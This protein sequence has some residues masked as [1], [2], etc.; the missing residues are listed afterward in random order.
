MYVINDCKTVWNNCLRFIRETIGEQTYKTWFE[1][2]VPVKLQ[3]EVLTIQVPNHFFYEWLEEHYVNVLRK[4]IDIEL[5]PQGRLEYSIIMEKGN[6]KYKPFTINVPT[7]GQA[8]NGKGQQVA[9]NTNDSRNLDYFGTPLNGKYVF[10]TFIEGDCNRL[11]RSA[12]YAVANK[13]GIT[14]FNPLMIFGGTG[15]G[16]THLVQ[17]IGNEVVKAKP[18]KFVHYVTSEKFSNQYIESIKSHTFQ[19][20]YNFYQSVDVLII[21]DVQF[22]AGKEKTQE[23][24]FQIF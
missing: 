4:A 13:P 23:T 16:K 2:I 24:F 17:A 9:K 1:P 6:E 14:S 15:L 3:N 5:G 8:G 12:G 22:M 18:E 11:A 19:N 20:F 21:D 7:S 10:D